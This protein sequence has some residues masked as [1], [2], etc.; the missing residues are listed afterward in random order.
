MSD[1]AECL[2]SALRR[3]AADLKANPRL[4]DLCRHGHCPKCGSTWIVFR[5]GIGRAQC[6]DCCWAWVIEDTRGGGPG[7]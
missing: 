5:T 3:F 1:R 2:K 6:R 4:G 7:S